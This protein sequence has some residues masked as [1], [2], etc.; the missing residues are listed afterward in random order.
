[1]KYLGKTS[2]FTLV[3]MILAT[4]IF[5]VMSIAVMSIYIQTTS[6]SNRLKATRHLSETSREITERISEDVKGKGISVKYSRYDDGTIGNDLW[7]NP[8]YQSGGELLTI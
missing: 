7:K 2:G 6:L 8:S 4:T 3:E 5:A 1:M